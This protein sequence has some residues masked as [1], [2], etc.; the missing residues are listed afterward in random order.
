MA[1]TINKV[2]LLGR[3]G[4]DIEMRYTPNGT[5][6]AQLRLATER[7]RQDGEV[8]ADWHNVVCWSKT[9]EAVNQYVGK[10]DRIYVAGRLVQNTWEGDD[11]QRR[12]R[13]EIHAS[14]VVFL[15]SR[16]GNGN[17]GNGQRRRSGHRGAGRR[18]PLLVPQPQRGARLSWAHHGAASLSRDGPA[19]I[20]PGAAKPAPHHAG[21]TEMARTINKVELLGRVGTD[22]EMKYTTGGTAVV[23]LRLATERRR[24]DGEVE[25]DWHS[26]VCWGKQAEAVNEYIGKGDRIYVAGRL[27]QN[28]W[29]GDDGQ[30]RYRTEI[31]ASEVVFLDSRGGNGNGGKDNGDAADVEE[32]VAASPF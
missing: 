32:P 23:Q 24:Q 11:G 30:R 31:H 28:T 6:V 18:L 8:E 22:P 25:A 1:R 2:E 29:E 7:R 10:G 16:G 12:Y 4:T 26:V 19:F 21:G 27:V 3:V 15:D 5:A 13:T 9:A 20:Q 14:E 17:G